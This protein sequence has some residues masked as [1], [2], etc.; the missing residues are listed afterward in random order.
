MYIMHNKTAKFITQLCNTN[1]QSI[2]VSANQ[3]AYY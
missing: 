3:P 1:K 2:H